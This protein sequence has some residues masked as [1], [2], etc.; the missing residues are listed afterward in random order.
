[1]KHVT[2]MSEL[3]RPGKGSGGVLESV[4]NIKA[5]VGL[6]L[7][8]EGIDVAGLVVVGGNYEESK[9]NG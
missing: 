2:V 4:G 8:L 5:S 1:M 3:E 6:V 9:M 7:L